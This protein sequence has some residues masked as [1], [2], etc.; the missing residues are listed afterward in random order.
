MKKFKSIIILLAVLLVLL[1]VYFFASP[2]W[3]E[4]EADETT[5]EQSHQIAAIDHTLLVGLELKHGEENLTF[6]LN[7]KATEWNWSEDG[8][9]PLDNMAFA[10]IVTALNNAKSK[11]KLEGVSSE[12]LAEYGLDAPSM[13][14]KFSFSDGTAKQFFIGNI[15]SFNSS[16]YISEAGA[17]NTV[18]MIESAVKTSLKLDIHDFVLEET[19]P[20]ITEAKILGVEYSNAGN[21][22]DFVYYPSGNSADYTDRYEWYFRSGLVEMSSLPRETP[23][24][25]DL[26]DSLSALITGLAFEECVGLDYTAGEFGFSESKKIVISYNADEGETGVLQKKEYVIYL[27]SQREDGSIYVHTDTSKLVYTL[28]S[29]D[30]WLDII[31]V[32]PAKLYPDELWL[33][34]Y[35]LIESMTFTA[36]GETVKVNVESTD[37]KISFSSDVSD[38]ADAIGALVKAFENMKTVSNVAY[39]DAS[40]NEDPKGEL[41][42]VY[43]A[44]RSQPGSGVTVSV[45]GYTDEYCVVSFDFMDGRLI[46]Y[47][48]ADAFI[49]MIFALTEKAA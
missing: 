14:V 33:P 37:G 44:L 42:A 1:A 20:V 16:Y 2:M 27:G 13:T 28:S 29:S 5:A 40:F 19:P 41:F 45:R 24:R 12:Q 7:D 8:D 48:D 36:G 17:P 4:D 6:A 49:D 21:Y 35:E 23:L 18:Y 38:D 30:E 43:V 34:N 11:Y 3:R 46:A 25:T 22:R 10:N 47:E 15:N 9:V 31:S 32:E 39:F 26:G